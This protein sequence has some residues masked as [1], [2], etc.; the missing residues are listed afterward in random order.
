MGLNGIIH[1]LCWPAVDMAQELHNL[2]WYGVY[3]LIKN[4]CPNRYDI[5][6]VF[7]KEISSNSEKA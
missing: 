4:V 7:V 2:Y 5:W 1:L 3:F 6:F